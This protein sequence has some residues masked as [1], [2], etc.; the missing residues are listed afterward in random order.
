MCSIDDSQ[1]WCSDFRHTRGTNFPIVH[2]VLKRSQFLSSR[3]GQQLGSNSCQNP[4]FVL[5]PS[6]WECLSWW[7]RIYHWIWG[8]VCSARWSSVSPDELFPTFD[9][10]L[11]LHYNT[12]AAAQRLDAIIPDTPIQ[13]VE[14]SNSCMLYEGE[15]PWEDY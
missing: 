10:S 14:F 2:F 9:L 3:P 6:S 7:R 12:T 5:F 1:S 8:V 13:L 4:D 11:I 15:D